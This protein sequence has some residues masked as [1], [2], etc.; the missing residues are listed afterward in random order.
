MENIRVVAVDNR[1]GWH[2]PFAARHLRVAFDRFQPDLVEAHLARAALLAGKI[3]PAGTWPLIARTHNSLNGKYYRH[4]DVI[5]PTTT[6]AAKADYHSNVPQQKFAGVIPNFSRLNPVSKVVN[7]ARP[8][9][10]VAAGRFVRK[11]GFGILLEAVAGLKSMDETFS[12]QI[13]GDGPELR[14]LKALAAELGLNEHVRFLG[15][16]TD[17]PDLIKEA[18]L[19][20][21]PSLSEPFGIILLEAMAM[22]TPIVATRCEGPLDVLDE[23]SAILV[24]KG[25]ASALSHGLR[26]ALQD[27]ERSRIRAEHALTVYKRRYTPDVVVPK[28]L[29][30]YH[31]VIR[32]RERGI[33]R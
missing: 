11:K 23:H 33:R 16:R 5:V 8:E 18:G 13:A 25:D 1:F 17:V 4:V 28:V 19:F 7:P 10:I 20:V 27:P 12:L 14:S 15:R 21:L 26:K 29:A 30:L 6:H 3:K 31:D 22:G 24:D 2:D 9:T 32:Q